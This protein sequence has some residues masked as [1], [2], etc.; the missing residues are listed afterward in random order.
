M[1]KNVLLIVFMALIGFAQAQT[2]VLVLESFKP[3]RGHFTAELQFAPFAENPFSE[4]G[5]QGRGFINDK[6]AIRLGLD[7]GMEGAKLVEGKGSAEETAKGRES[8]FKIAPGFEYHM[9]NWRR[10]SVYLGGELFF[11]TEGSKVTVE[12]DGY[13]YEAKNGGEDRGY[14]NSFG[15]NAIL[16]SDFYIVRG[17]YMGAELKLGYGMR[18]EK[19][20][21]VTM[22]GTTEKY[23]DDYKYSEWGVGFSCEPRIRL[24]WRF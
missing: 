10:V 21:E 2:E 24:G 13:S 3:D 17:L 6:W 8:M 11:A 9:G 14:Y 19:D 4:M 20:G 15:L 1:K 7:F 5:L 23:W 12:G 18:S 22:D 16:G